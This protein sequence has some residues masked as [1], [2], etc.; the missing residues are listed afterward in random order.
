[1]ER[2][3]DRV[4]LRTL[5]LCDLARGEI[6]A[7]AEGDQLAVTLLEPPDGAGEGDPAKGVVLEVA[8]VGRV[9]VLCGVLKCR[10]PSLDAPARDPDQPRD[11]LAFLRV[12]ALAVASSASGPSPTR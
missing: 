5:E 12:V 1:V 8:V 10:R 3:F 11:R 2:D 6:G 4:R 9:D 7:V